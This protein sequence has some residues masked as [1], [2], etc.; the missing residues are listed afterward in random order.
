MLL[1]SVIIFQHAQRYNIVYMKF[2]TLSDALLSNI[3]I[4]FADAYL[5]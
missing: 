5:L 1:H 2:I 3:K 4:N